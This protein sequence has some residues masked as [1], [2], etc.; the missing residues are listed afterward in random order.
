M[1]VFMCMY[2]EDREPGI[3]DPTLKTYETMRPGG[4]GDLTCPNIT[5]L[6]LVSHTRKIK[7]DKML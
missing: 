2:E 3:I 6:N 7:G 4:W 1:C 5:C